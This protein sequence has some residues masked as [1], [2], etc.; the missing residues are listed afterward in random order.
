MRLAAELA[1][2]RRIAAAVI[3]TFAASLACA[4]ETPAYE[5]EKVKA[6]F[7]IRFADFVQWPKTALPETN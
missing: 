6:A 1:T 2:L 7:L 4:Q 5:E 3:L